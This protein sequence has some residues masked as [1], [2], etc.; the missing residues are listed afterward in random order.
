MKQRGSALIIS[1]LLIAAVGGIA[2]GIGRLLFIES[3]MAALY[4]NG[5][6][7]YYAAESGIEEGFL[8][9]RYNR[10][11][12]VPFGNFEDSN[13]PIYWT[14]GEDKVFRSN[15]QLAQTRVG[16]DGNFVGRDA[17]ES[18]EYADSSTWSNYIS[19]QIYDLRIGYIGTN[20]LPFY[21]QDLS[22]PE[23]DLLDDTDIK[24]QDYATGEYSFL[25]IPKDESIKINLDGFVFGNQDIDLHVKFYDLDTSNNNDLSNLEKCKGL[26]EL[27]LLVDNGGG[28][29]EK[30]EL[31][32]YNPSGCASTLGI[33][34]TKMMQTFNSGVINTSEFYY[35][36]DD[37]IDS[38]S[39][40]Q[41]FTV[42]SSSKIS[43][44]IKPLYSD[45]AIGLTNSGCAFDCNNKTN[46][47][48]GPIS[49]VESTGY[50]GGISRKLVASIDRQS[51]TLYD[52]YDYV[53]YMNTNP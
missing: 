44:F 22:D 33:A 47:V 52:L 12:E 15:I 6:V 51:G 18:L 3:T 48:T 27:K 4:E 40:S 25:R 21:G 35:N 36:I 39:A 42:N 26:V 10:N 34:E 28:I 41:G 7:A 11:A 37:I 17:T 5:A 43:M 19:E 2:F 32:N 14:L 24:H 50:F 13:N 31:L 45:A 46:V 8:R 53:I 1:M 23:N 38:V 20:G 49:K 29:R 30:K 9:Y 16:S